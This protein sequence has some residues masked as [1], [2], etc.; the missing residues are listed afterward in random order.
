VVTIVIDGDGRGS[1]IPY[2][3][4]LQGISTEIQDGVEFDFKSAISSAPKHTARA[5]GTH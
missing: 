3:E 5:S 1:T 2:A 4:N